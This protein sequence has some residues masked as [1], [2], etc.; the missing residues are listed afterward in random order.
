MAITATSTVAMVRE[1]FP[2]AVV[3]TL[4]FRGEETI[5]LLPEQLVTVCAYLLKNQ[6]YS[7]LSSVTAVDWVERE[8]RFDVVYHLL[9]I[10][11]QSELRLK[12][13]VGQAGAEHP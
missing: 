4:D 9:S 7:F 13:R 5:V 8:P 3:E 2:H 6:Q 1:K 11:N 10:Q 12:V